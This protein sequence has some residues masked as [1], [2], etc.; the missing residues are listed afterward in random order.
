MPEIVDE[1]ERNIEEIRQKEARRLLD[2][3]VKKETQR[4]AALEAKRR[5][6]CSPE[7]KKPEE[8]IM[9]IVDEP[10]SEKALADNLRAIAHDFNEAVRAAMSV[11]LQV[12]IDI[13]MMSGTFSTKQYPF[14]RIAV[15]KPL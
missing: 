9:K 15:S 2:L 12:D 4:F 5:K 11:G 7:I 10:T 8:G 1:M 13:E 6:A 3:L 14:L